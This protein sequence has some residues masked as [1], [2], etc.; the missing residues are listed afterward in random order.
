[1]QSYRAR[2]TENMA[3]EGVFMPE[4]ELNAL[5]VV[6]VRLMVLEHIGLNPGMY[7]DARV[8]LRRKHPIE[9]GLKLWEWIAE[10]P[11]I[12]KHGITA[13]DV[14]RFLIEARRIIEVFGMELDI[15]DGFKLLT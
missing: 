3:L 12:R 13:Q 9:N 10:Q 5:T 11:D 14:C 8:R 2:N 7:P 1:M 15:H 4:Y 6:H